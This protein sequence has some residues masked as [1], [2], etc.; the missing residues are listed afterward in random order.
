MSEKNIFVTGDRGILKG[1]QKMTD[2]DRK[3]LADAASGE[4]C[5]VLSGE[6]GV[7]A[8]KEL[9]AAAQETME[10]F[11][12]NI[13][14]Q[15]THERAVRVRELRVDEQWSW[16]GVA[17]QTF[18]EWGADAEWRP[19]SNQLAGMA[20][21]QVAAAVFGEDENQEPWN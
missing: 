16:R 20:L 11:L 7:K 10:T 19:A 4:G 12:A 13:K 9:A 14:A 8:L 1:G 5:L 18:K 21:C 3:V 6:E 15:M 17:E 2:T